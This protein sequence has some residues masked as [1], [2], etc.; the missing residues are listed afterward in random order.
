MA[1]KTEEHHNRTHLAHEV[2]A[3]IVGT[4]LFPS[5]NKLSGG[6]RGRASSGGP[7]TPFQG[8]HQEALEQGNGGDRSSGGGDC[9]GG[10]IGDNVGAGQSR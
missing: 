8:P 4:C 10:E 5:P 1:R 3:D 7:W 6:D 2:G 9:G